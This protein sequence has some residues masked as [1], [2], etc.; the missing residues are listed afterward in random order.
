M[1]PPMLRAGSPLPANPAIT[2]AERRRQWEWWRL[3]QTT[4]AE[5]VYLAAQG[6]DPRHPPPPVT[7]SRNSAQT[8]GPDDR[9]LRYRRK[10]RAAKCT[11]SPTCLVACPATGPA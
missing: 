7:S 3:H 8:G 5:A 11:L 6:A 2:D 10:R 9:G 1:A 4:A